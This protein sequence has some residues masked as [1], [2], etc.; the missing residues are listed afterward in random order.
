MTDIRKVVQ[1]IMNRDITEEDYRLIEPIVENLKP[2]SM[3][4]KDTFKVFLDPSFVIDDPKPP[5]GAP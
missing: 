3:L 1:K 5:E 2:G 4:H